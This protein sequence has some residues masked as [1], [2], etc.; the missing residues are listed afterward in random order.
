MVP[1]GVLLYRAVVSHPRMAWG[2]E[3]W[4][5]GSSYVEPLTTEVEI[6][7]GIA[8]S[9]RTWVLPLLPPRAKEVSMA[10]HTVKSRALDSREVGKSR[11]RLSRGTHVAR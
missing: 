6:I 3:M 8:S 11:G 7:H 2:A 1:R 5:P 4:L 9:P 10:Q